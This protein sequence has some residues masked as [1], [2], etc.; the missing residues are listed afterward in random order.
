MKSASHKGTNTVQFHLHEVPGV[1]KIIERRMVSDRSWWE[2]CWG[3]F[4]GGGV[5]DLQDERSSGRGLHSSGL[6]VLLN[7]T[8]SEMVTM[9][10]FILRVFFQKIFLKRSLAVWGIKGQYAAWRPVSQGS[11]LVTDSGQEDRGSEH[12]AYQRL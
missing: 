7:C 1:V 6:H 2:G 9:A 12:G 8:H 5:S 4:N 10:N 11:G 3:L